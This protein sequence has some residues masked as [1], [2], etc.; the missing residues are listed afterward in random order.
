MMLGR[1]LFLALT[2]LFYS[3]ACFAKDD[4][5]FLVVGFGNVS[6]GHFLASTQN[7]KL[8]KTWTLTE[9]NGTK[10]WEEKLVYLEWAKGF[11]SGTNQFLGR[12]SY[13]KDTD[14]A[15]EAW[16]LNYCGQHPTT[17]FASALVQFL[18]DEG[19]LPR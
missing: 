5:V 19:A 16:L 6:C 3:L 8:G 15:L 9:A 18:A 13:A 1:T 7:S 12:R 11:I 4:D 2:V 17:L 14:A 10:M